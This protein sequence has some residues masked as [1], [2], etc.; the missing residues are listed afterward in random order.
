MKVAIIDLGTNTFNLL[1][2]NVSHLDFQI[3]YKTKIGVKLGKGGINNK[4]ITPEAFKRGID[5]IESHYNKATELKVDKIVAFATSAMR[6][7]SNGKEFVAQIKELFGIQIE[8]IDGHREAELIYKGVKLAL[9]FPEDNIV[10][11]DIGG[12]SVEFIIANKE[13]ILWKHSFEIGMARV[14]DAFPV[15]NPILPEEVKAIENYVEDFLKIFWDA[16][17]KYQPKV[18]IGSSGSFD[19]FA[20]L[21][22]AEKNLHEI[23]FKENR[24]FLFEQ[25]SYFDLH[26]KLLQS[27]LEERK[28]M[29]GMELIRVDMIV[30]AS[31]FVNFIL[32]KTK[33]A[34]M[35]QA[36]FALKEG[37]LSELMN[38]KRNL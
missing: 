33:I 29:K 25:Q 10:I 5:A 13:E 4:Q 18:L 19:T 22:L 11:V 27:S 17:K 36:N 9:E 31:I 26:E 8:I 38:A 23:W 12:G 34:S 3:E 2:A 30:L 15:S 6:N 24:H 20:S 1:V 21:I 35:Y 7:A 32:N 14:L 37:V 28:N 16:Y